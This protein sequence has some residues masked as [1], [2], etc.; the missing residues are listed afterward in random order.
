M[1]TAYVESLLLHLPRHDLCR[2][3]FPKDIATRSADLSTNCKIEIGVTSKETKRKNFYRAKFFETLILALKVSRRVFA[4]F[5][6][7][8]FR[9]NVH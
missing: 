9:N 3:I 7:L 4:N 5:K 6:S 2:F 1:F 8:V